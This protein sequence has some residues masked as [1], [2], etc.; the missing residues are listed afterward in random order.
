MRATL[1]ILLLLGA[2][3]TAVF[4]WQATIG[5]GYAFRFGTAGGLIA[6]RWPLEYQRLVDGLQQSGFPW[7]WNP[8]GAFLLSLPVALLLAAIA[9]AI[10]LTRE[11]GRSERRRRSR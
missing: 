11:D 5:Q 2:L 3:W 1:T 4:D 6:A 8:V 7:L 9:G 10:W